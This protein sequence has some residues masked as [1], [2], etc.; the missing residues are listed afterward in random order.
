M[1]GV[2]PGQAGTARS[3]GVLC[4]HLF[5]LVLCKVA[6]I[7]ELF[8]ATREVLLSAVACVSGNW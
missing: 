3:I 8:I 4:S 1:A 5:A 7:G 2:D 6:S